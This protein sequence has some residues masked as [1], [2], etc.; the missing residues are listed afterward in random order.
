MEKLRYTRFEFMFYNNFYLV[1]TFY[2]IQNLNVVDEFLLWIF[3]NFG[4]RSA[5]FFRYLSSFILV[6]EI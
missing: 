4:F 3:E 6:S 2:R 1:L 5:L